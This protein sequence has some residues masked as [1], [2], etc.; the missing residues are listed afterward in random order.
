MAAE[1]LVTEALDGFGGKAV[2]VCVDEKIGFKEEL[3]VD[4]ID[5]GVGVMMSDEPADAVDEGGRIA[6]GGE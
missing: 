6:E 5:V 1:N 2:F 4:G 3:V